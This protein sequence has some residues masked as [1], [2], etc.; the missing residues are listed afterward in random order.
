MTVCAVVRMELVSA[1][2]TGTAPLS[3][4]EYSGPDC[5]C[6]PDYCYNTNYPNVS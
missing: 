3:G 2:V 5:G 1:S 4:E 6:D